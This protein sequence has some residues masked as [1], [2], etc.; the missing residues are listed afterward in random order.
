MAPQRIQTGHIQ[1][2][3]DLVLQPTIA[4]HLHGHSLDLYLYLFHAP[5]LSRSIQTTSGNS[6]F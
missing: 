6:Q 5:S 2:S 4:I 1:T 3:N